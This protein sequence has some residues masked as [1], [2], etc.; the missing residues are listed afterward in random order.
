MK[1]KSNIINLGIL[2]HVD[3]GKTT[4]S[5]ALLYHSG[6][7][8][9]MGNVDRGTT[10]TD[11][12]HLERQR[13]MT[14]RASTVSFEWDDHKINLIDTPGHMDFIAEVMRSL[15]VLD[16][17]ILV[18][19]AR[20]GV[21]VQTRIIWQKL[22]E[23][24]IPTILFVNKIDSPAANIKGVLNQIRSRLSEDIV[25]MQQ[26]HGQGT[27]ESLLEPLAPNDEQNRDN[28]LLADEA[29]FRR[30]SKAR[31]LFA[32]DYAAALAQ[33]G[34]AGRLF[35]VFFGSALQSVGIIPLLNAVTT[36]FTPP[37]PEQTPLRA[38]IYK[39]EYD[40]AGH[41][42]LYVRIFSGTMR[43]RDRIALPNSEECIVIRMLYTLEHGKRIRSDYAAPGDIALLMDN[44]RLTC[45][46]ILG[47]SPYQLR[48]FRYAQPLLSVSISPGENTLRHALV[49]ALTIL[50]AEDPSLS[51]SINPESEEISIRLYGRLQLEIIAGLLFERFNTTVCFSA[52]KTVYRD[53]PRE[54]AI[55]QIGIGEKSNL[56]YAG[57]TLSIEP[58]PTGSGIQ[59]ESHVSYGY[60]ERPFQNAVR[61]GI[62]RG[63]EAGICNPVTDARVIL[64]DADY[65]SVM[66]TPSDFRTLAPAVIKKA[67]LHSGT[68]CLAPWQR[69]HLT[70]PCGHE[71][72]ILG[73][74]VRM[75]ATMENITYSADEFTI[76]GIVSLDASKDY[77]ADLLARTGGQGLFSSEFYAYIAQDN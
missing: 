29:L 77:A 73:D 72:R 67:L 58:L 46:D 14:I 25:I 71:K 52:L 31:P 62:M 21:Q 5:E 60:L 20:E 66:S 8:S 68:I 51:L 64:L 74:L 7:K 44:S 2:A 41:R 54:K 47:E 4:L 24:N 45:G 13:G 9:A 39:L 17:V 10:T 42:L 28:I 56:L 40:E 16:G 23:L 12:M 63:L 76:D 1:T 27:K 57:I 15:A 69:Y 53:K 65:D 38:F 37:M 32:A 18:I 3:A 49:A 59:Y 6:T 26:V 36:Y 30:F 33:A 43:I 75:G 48:A 61:D 22:R 11:S 55:A 34:A 19:S 50:N 35:P 70:A